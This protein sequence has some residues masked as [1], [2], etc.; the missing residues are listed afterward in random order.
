[1]AAYIAYG[2]V[3]LMLIMLAAEFLRRHPI[4]RLHGKDKG[5]SHRSMQSIRVSEPSLPLGTD[6]SE[7]QKSKNL[8]SST[9]ASDGHLMGRDA[10]VFQMIHYMFV[11]RHQ[12]RLNVVVINDDLEYHFDAEEITEDFRA[13]YHQA[14]RLSPRVVPYP[15]I[16]FREGSLVNLGNG[17]DIN[18]D[19]QA[20]GQ[21]R[22]S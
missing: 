5:S 1:M 10:W 16:A 14:G 12:S 3:G 20:R 21:A 7:P 15:I 9:T 2:L 22:Q 4:K 17:G 13:T 6:S 18:W 19:W 8:P 11:T